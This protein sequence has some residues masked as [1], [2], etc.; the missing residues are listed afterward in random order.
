MQKFVVPNTL[1]LWDIKIIE[2]FY[3]T[4]ITDKFSSAALGFSVFRNMNS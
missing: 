3:E 4:D 2:E 1:K